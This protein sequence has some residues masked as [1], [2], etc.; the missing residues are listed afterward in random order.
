MLAAKDAYETYSGK[1]FHRDT[2]FLGKECIKDKEF[3]CRET[4]ATHI[5][6]VRTP[7]AVKK[8]FIFIVI[9]ILGTVSNTK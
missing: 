7:V 4:E 2:Y 9:I 3:K 5:L 1:K 8:C 6:T